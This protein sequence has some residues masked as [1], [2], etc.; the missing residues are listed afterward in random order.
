MEGQKTTSHCY[1]LKTLKIN[2]SH[3]ER[4]QCYEMITI[5]FFPLLNGYC[6]HVPPG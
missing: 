1:G 3:S 6:G 2:K 5:Y 4:K